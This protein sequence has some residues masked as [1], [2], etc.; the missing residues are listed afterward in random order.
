M[1]LSN[2]SIEILTKICLIEKINLSKTE[3]IIDTFHTKIRDS[4]K[5]YKT[6]AGLGDYKMKSH[7][8]LILLY[9]CINTN[10]YNRKLELILIFMYSCYKLDDFH[11]STLDF[12]INGFFDFL[13]ENDNIHSLIHKIITD[14]NVLKKVKKEYF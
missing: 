8:F 10:T 12:N 5:Y 4:F 11:F 9:L 1:T 7:D 14:A 13:K 6:H 3:K 2:D